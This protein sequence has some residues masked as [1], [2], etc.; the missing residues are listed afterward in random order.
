MSIFRNTI[1]LLLLTL[2]SFG[3]VVCVESDGDSCVCPALLDMVTSPFSPFF[4][5]CGDNDSC[6]CDC[7]PDDCEGDLVSQQS[8][9]LA[10]IQIPQEP[11][12]QDLDFSTL[13]EDMATLNRLHHSSFPGKG[14]NPWVSTPPDPYL[15]GNIPVVIST[16]VLR[17]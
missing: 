1:M 2:S 7:E 11:A 4:D 6:P 14:D 8:G 16:I 9:L 13:G 5:A 3:S 12:G 17:V 15:L 10:S